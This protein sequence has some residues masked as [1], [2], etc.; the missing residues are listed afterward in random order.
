MISPLTISGQTPRTVH[1]IG[2]DL[3]L[4]GARSHQT[5]SVLDVVFVVVLLG[6]RHLLPLLLQPVLGR[7]LLLDALSEVPLED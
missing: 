2:T 7:L 5:G 4:F 6:A 1:A 3:L